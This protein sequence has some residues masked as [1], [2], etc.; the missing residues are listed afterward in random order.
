M[1]KKS[2]FSRCG[3][4]LVL[5]CGIDLGISFCFSKLAELIWSGETPGAVSLILTFVAM[6][7]IALPIAYLLL[8]KIPE[9]QVEEVSITKKQWFLF[10]AAT[11]GVSI[12]GN[13]V[14][15][16]INGIVTLLVG[17]GS[18]NAI[19]DMMFSY[20]IPERIVMLLFACVVAPIME[21]LIFRRMILRKFLP[22]GE[23][24]A[25][26][27]SGVM[28]GLFH[29]NFSQ[30]IYASIM[31]MALGYLYVRTGKLRYNILMHAAVN[32]IS[33]VLSLLFMDNFMIAAIYS[34]F[35]YGFMIYGIVVFFMKRKKIHFRTKED[36]LQKGEIAKT[37]WLNPGMI[38]FIL[39]V[40]AEIIHAFLLG[41]SL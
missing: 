29:G 23:K 17:H 30:I 21:E 15:V 5:A 36:D 12:L 33:T 13:I 1:S 9:A 6:D 32:T 24:L 14:T 34:L 2:V 3:W 28:F 27:L 10:F 20:S 22:Y 35:V 41:G 26:I 4:I 18:Y 8:K 38:V 19:M 16:I 40:L 39:V 31:G 11:Y 37:V 7:F 25:V